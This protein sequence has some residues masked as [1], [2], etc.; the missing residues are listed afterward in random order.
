MFG[1]GGG[2]GCSDGLLYG[3]GGPCCEGSGRDEMW[4]NGCMSWMGSEWV[5]LWWVG[6]MEC[7]GVGMWLRGMQGRD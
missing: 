6:L 5:G 1:G 7:D 3:E 4:Q 2:G